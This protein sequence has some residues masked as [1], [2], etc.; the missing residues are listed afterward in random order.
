MSHPLANFQLEIYNNG[1]AGKLPNLPLTFPELEQ[2]SREKLDPGAFDYVAGAAGAEET[3]RANREAFARWRIIPRMLR[4]VSSRNLS[5]KLLGVEMPA[6]V[7]LAP[8]G[9][10]SIIHPEAE[11]AV[12]RAAAGLGL[13]MLLSTVSS[14]SMER[15]A[16]ESGTASRWFQ[17]YWPKERKFVASLLNRAEQAGYGALVVTLDSKLL[18]WRPRDLARSYLPFLRGEGIANFLSDPVFCSMLARPPA[19]DMNAAIVRWTE[20]FSDLSITWDDLKFLRKQTRLPVILKGVLHTDD[21]RC[22]ADH[23]MDAIVVSNHGGRQ[24]DGAVAALDCLPGAIAAAGSMPVLFDSG[25]RSGA[26][27]FKALALGAKAVLI[28][29]PYVYG[30]ALSGEAG[31]KAVIRA[32]LA[33]LDLTMALSGIASL[34]D[35]SLEALEERKL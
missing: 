25:I 7:L 15:V 10:L 23:G 31:V 1:L 18:G 13:T 4:N 19:E 12:A 28:G 3:M 6:P 30:L 32:L 29:R 27:I 5:V 35:L 34:K 24:V 16:Q 17:L 33:D 2:R 26:D 21:V 11:L 22:A 9:V 14:F 8:I 20:L